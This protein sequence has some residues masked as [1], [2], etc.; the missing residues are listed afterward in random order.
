[1]DRRH[2]TTNRRDFL[3]QTFVA[4]MTGVLGSPGAGL[5]AREE[6]E[7]AIQIGSRRELFV[8]DFII[9]RLGGEAELRLHHPTRRE[10]VIHHD[11]PWEGTASGYHTVF[12]DNGSYRMYYRGWDLEVTPGKLS[13]VHPAVTCYAESNDGIHWT[14]PNLGIIEYRGS[15]QNNII[16]DGIGTQNFMP[17]VDENPDCSGEARYKALAGIKREGGLFAFKSADGVHWSRMSEEPVIT[18]GAFDSGNLAFWDQ[19]SQQYRAYWRTFSAGVTEKDDWRP[20]G[21]RTIRTAKSHDFL[22]WE[23]EAD[24]TYVDSPAEHLYENQIKPYYRAPQILIGFPTRYVERGW[25]PSM[26]ALPD[27]EKRELRAS[28]VERYGTAVTEGLIMASRDGVRFKR[29]NEAFLRPGIQRADSWRYAHQNIAR[30]VVETKSS[31]PGA[32]NELSLYALSGYWHGDG[33]Q[34]T[35]YTLRLDGFVSASAPLKGGE[36]VTKVLTFSGDQLKVNFSSSAAGNLR[37][38]IQD[39]ERRPLEG[40]SIKEAHDTFGDEVERTVHWKHGAD[41]S[42]LAGQPVRLRFVLNDADLYAFRFARG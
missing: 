12:Q 28:S 32:P 8:D 10:M 34:L 35:R 17:M 7:R 25:S 39:P 21:Y 15:R 11:S 24:L 20:A 9:D 31:T 5:S 37:V 40:Y 1:M 4:T 19:S 14:K 29:W 2:S 3:G 27:L 26:R 6:T 38:E 18:K 30:H 23:H 13:E 16:L 22:H 41:V 42:Q 33:C 36:L